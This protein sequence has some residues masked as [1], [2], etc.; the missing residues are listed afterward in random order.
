MSKRSYFNLGTPVWGEDFF[1]RQNEVSQILSLLES[2]SAV[3]F[4]SL[5]RMGK[6][7]LL[8]QIMYLCKNEPAWRGFLPFYLDLAATDSTKTL[9]H[10]LL[11]VFSVTM[12]EIRRTDNPWHAIERHLE[13]TSGD[14]LLLMDEFGWW[15]R[16]ERREQDLASLR[17]FSRRAF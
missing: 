16:S 6:S 5:R 3:N 2:R 10:Y 11:Q 4:F 17:S 15:L 8:R 1:G 9:G 14:R 13:R 12:G 7:S